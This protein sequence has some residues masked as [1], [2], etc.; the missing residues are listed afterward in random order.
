MR[1]KAMF[2]VFMVLMLMASMVT[3]AQTTSSGTPVPEATEEFQP[4]ATSE[5][6]SSVA[7]SDLPPGAYIPGEDR[8]GSCRHI[9]KEEAERLDTSNFGGADGFVLDYQFEWT[10]P[11]DPAEMAAIVEQKDDTGGNLPSTAKIRLA[12]EVAKFGKNGGHAFVYLSC[13]VDQLMDGW[14]DWFGPYTPAQIRRQAA[15]L[16]LP[17]QP[18]IEYAREWCKLVEEGSEDCVVTALEE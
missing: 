6:A 10:V 4:E 16:G 2:F 7:E 3:S 8:G 9:S 17:A 11:T 1:T 18:Y 13:R 14:I 5:L 12:G 15:R